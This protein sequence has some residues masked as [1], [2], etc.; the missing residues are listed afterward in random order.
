MKFVH[1]LNGDAMVEAFTATG[2]AGETL[3]WAEAAIDGPLAVDMSSAAIRDARAEWIERH[4]GIAAADYRGRFDARQ[5]A[6]AGLPDEAELELVLWFERDLFCELHLLDLLGRTAA[7]AW[8]VAVVHPPTLALAPAQLAEAFARR[9]ACTL[10]ERAQARAAW[11]ALVGT[12]DRGGA[13]FELGSDSTGSDSNWFAGLLASMQ[14]DWRGCFPDARGLTRFD[15]LALELAA[16]G[17]SPRELFSQVCERAETRGL[18]LGDLQVWLRLASL[19]ERGLLASDLP[20]PRADRDAPID[21][22]SLRTR[23]EGLALLERD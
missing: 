16:A 11:A 2:L 23:P 21:R 5:L 22:P 20:L 4:S 9:H 8:R 12:S 10:A 17:C 7:H 3:V 6:W 19:V 13:F 15:A 14:S 1:V 18:G